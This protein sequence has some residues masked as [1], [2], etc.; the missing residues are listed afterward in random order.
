MLKT[1]VSKNSD[2][3]EAKVANHAFDAAFVSE[4]R[5][6][7]V[8]RSLFA[9]LKTKKFAFVETFSLMTENRTCPPGAYSE[10]WTF[11]EAGA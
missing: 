5:K 3:T 8:S 10:S 6:S 1:Y 11:S 9:T 7:E 4:K 2:W